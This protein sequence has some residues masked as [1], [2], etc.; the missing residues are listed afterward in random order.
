MA[1][2]KLAAPA[3]AAYRL[4]PEKKE[5]ELIDGGG[6]YLRVRRGP[7]GAIQRAWMLRYTLPGQGRQRLML[8]SYPSLS[9]QAARQAAEAQQ[10]L[11]AQGIDPKV[12]REQE[13][14]ERLAHELATSRGDI[15]TTVAE[16]Y[17]R[18]AADYASTRHTDGGDGVAG[19]FRRH[20]LDGK[21]GKLRLD[22]V[23]PAHV[24]TLLD[25]LR[26]DRGLTRTCGHV[27]SLIRQIF[28]WGLTR[29]YVQRDP[30][31]GLEAAEWN[32]Q[33]VECE[34]YLTHDEIK[35]LY[36]L[37]A[38]SRWSPTWKHAVWLITA[39]GSRVEETMLTERSHVDM[40]RGIWRI[41]AENQKKNRKIKPK[42]FYIQL[43]PF[44]MEH[45][46]ALMELAGASK[47]LFPSSR[48]GGQD[49]H[50]GIKSLTKAMTDR[51]C[52][53]GEE[54]QGRTRSASSA[55]ILPGG[56][57]TPHDLRR[58]S[59]TIMQ[60]LRVDSAV[61]DRCLNH[62][63]P[64]KIQRIYQRG[65]LAGAMKEAWWLLGAELERLT[66]EAKIELEEEMQ[67]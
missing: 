27:L 41:P 58:T 60:E 2:Y 23:R 17:E 47:W 5:G 51:Q 48:G 54:L 6:L 53:P 61:V 24:T 55:L 25:S 15:P 22:L 65:E 52:A 43:S 67:G 19:T 35:L 62:A 11:I 37:L 56:L 26:D 57:Y 42:D 45:M 39:V 9:L 12:I 44:A 38:R 59:A 4:P 66:T 20:I 30:T 32:G 40:E 28:N 8:G 33:S 31:A 49:R 1:I 64:G 50:V 36:Q 13:A 34:R 3:I 16:L 7:Q 14:A 29:E 46:A 21:F 10:A 63:I 18:W